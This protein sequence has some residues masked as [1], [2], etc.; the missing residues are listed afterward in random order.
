[1]C[2]LEIRFRQT[3]LNDSVKDSFFFILLR[4]LL[5]EERRDVTKRMNRRTNQQK[6]HE[7]RMDPPRISSVLFS[8]SLFNDEFDVR[9]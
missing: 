1:M 5:E 7:K 3:I 8:I 6:Q 4:S 9:L 2:R